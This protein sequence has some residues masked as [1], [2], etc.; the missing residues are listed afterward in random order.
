MVDSASGSELNPLLRTHEMAL[1]TIDWG[2]PE[3]VQRWRDSAR[4]HTSGDFMMVIEQPVADLGW[5]QAANA[6]I[7][8]AQAEVVIL[9]DSGVEVIGDVAVALVEA[10]QDPTVAVAGPFGVRGKGT[11]KEFESHPG[12][13]VDAIEGYCMAFRKADAGTVGGFDAKFRF[14][15]IA[16][17]EFSFRLRDQGGRRALVVPGL[18]IIKHAHRLWES[19]PEAERARLSKKNFYRFLDRWGGRE[20]LLTDRGHQGGGAQ[21]HQQQARQAGDPGPH[22]GTDQIPGARDNPRDDRPPGRRAEQDAEHHGL[23]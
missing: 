11:L 2:W 17:I 13:E 22:A 4:R 1:V 18:P 20:D 3:D 23:G 10:L 6:A 19:T 15:R 5:A 16:D 21:R 9:F 14:Y 7:E 12:P 8:A